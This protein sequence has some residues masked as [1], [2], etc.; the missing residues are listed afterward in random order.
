MH[1][2]SVGNANGNFDRHRKQAVRLFMRNGTGS[3]AASSRSVVR[4]ARP[5]PVPLPW[6]SGDRSRAQMRVIFGFSGS[7][8]LD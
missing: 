1:S 7:S 6:L 2:R 8:A 3:I 4:S 5:Q